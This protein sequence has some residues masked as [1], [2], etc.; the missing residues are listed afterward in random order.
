ML[1]A[2][3]GLRLENIE[4][5]PENI[6]KSRNLLWSEFLDEEN[7][8]LVNTDFEQ[9]PPGRNNFNRRMAGNKMAPGF[10][11]QGFLSHGWRQKKCRRVSCSCYGPDFKLSQNYQWLHRPILCRP[12]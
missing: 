11:F 1:K 8:N 10:A 9:W 6:I 5:L 12:N 4:N 2:D 3:I 7:E